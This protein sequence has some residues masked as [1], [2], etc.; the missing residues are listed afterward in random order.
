ML[1]IY[2]NKKS[3][4]VD[5]LRKVDRRRTHCLYIASCYFNPRSADA[6][7][8]DLR[9]VVSI[10]YIE[11]LIDRKTAEAI[12][13]E[14]LANWLDSN[15]GLNLFVS[16]SS[17]LFHTKGYA[18]LHFD[19][20]EKVASGSLVLGSANVTEAGL[21]AANGNIECLID[22][23]EV[24]HLRGFYESLEEMNWV[25]I[26]ELDNYEKADVNFQYALISR[27]YFIHP[28]SGDINALLAVRYSLTEE[29]EEKTTTDPAFSSLGFNLDALTVAKSYI[30][31]DPASYRSD[32]FKVIKRNYGIECRLGYWVPKCIFDSASEGIPGYEFFKKELV[33][34]LKNNVVSIKKSILSDYEVL[35]KRNLINALPVSPEITFEQKA[36]ELISGRR[37]ELLSRVFN[38]YQ[39]FE[40]PYDVS[41]VSSISAIYDEITETSL[42]KLK[43][44]KAQKAWLACIE[45]VSFKPLASFDNWQ[46]DDD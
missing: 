2:R 27:G 3:V 23:Q 25:E 14:V 6:L 29:G 40:F 16:K 12:G 38:K 43:K 26:D 21:C 45:S 33:K 36:N 32:Q 9:E 34:Y 44:N 28:W 30:D 39:R 19:D 15:E 1:N 4:L 20:D 17:R 7:I 31:F 13:K 8:H 11:I 35:L 5:L 41:D 22:T 46:R 37:E 10:D 42:S 18:L 24:R